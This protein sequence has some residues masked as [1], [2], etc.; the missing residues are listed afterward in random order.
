MITP[1]NGAATMTFGE[2][3]VVELAICYSSVAS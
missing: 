3:C 2:S 1:G